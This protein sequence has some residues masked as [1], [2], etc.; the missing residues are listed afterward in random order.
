MSAGSYDGEKKWQA[1][2][3]EGWMLN[4]IEP[5]LKVRCPGL[6]TTLVMVLLKTKRLPALPLL[7]NRYLKVLPLMFPECVLLNKRGNHLVHP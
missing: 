2:Y 5:K 1:I 3:M 6:P 7:Q 4:R